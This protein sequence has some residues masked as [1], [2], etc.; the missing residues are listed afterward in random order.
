MNWETVAL[1]A[2]AVGTL[3]LA[4]GTL[5]SV[6]SANR[7]A[8]LAPAPTPD[9]IVRNDAAQPASQNVAA[10][11]SKE[12]PPDVEDATTTEEISALCPP[13]RF[14]LLE[15]PCPPQLVRFVQHHRQLM[16]I[17]RKH[18][19]RAHGNLKDDPSTCTSG[20][21]IIPLER[22][23]EPASEATSAD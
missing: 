9:R 22:S 6:R 19:D 23:F 15:S 7:S 1:L 8:R 11:A 18:P 3:G 21:T 5:A 4:A 10:R 14:E 12:T 20:P 13:P 16:I 2:T 17:I